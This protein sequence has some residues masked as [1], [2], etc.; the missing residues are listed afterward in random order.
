MIVSVELPWPHKGL[1]PNARLQ[2]FAKAKIFKATKQDTYV[3]THRA[4]RTAGVKTVRVKDGNSAKQWRGGVVNLKMICT[5][6]ILRYRDEDNMIATCKAVFDGIAEAMKVNDTIFH[7]RE[8]VWHEPV[9]PGNLTIVLD[10]EEPN[11]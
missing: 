7:F 3:R 6:P 2:V 4:L 10:W 1:S 11:E 9:K 8:Q 5:P